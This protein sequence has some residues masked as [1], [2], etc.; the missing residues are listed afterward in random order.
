MNNNL[1]LILWMWKQISGTRRVIMFS[2]FLGVIRVASSMFF[3]WISKEMI[4]SAVENR[5]N[6]MIF[7]LGL[8][9]TM[10]I[11]ILCTSGQGY[12]LVR[13]EAYTSNKLRFKLFDKALN[14]IWTGKEKW[15]SGDVVNRLEEDVRVMTNMLCGVLPGTLVTLMQFIAAFIF[16]WTM[17]SSL[18][19]VIVC[20]LPAF[21]TVAAFAVHKM[22]KFTVDIRNADG[23]V[24]SLIQESLQKR[25]V[26]ITL[27]RVNYVLDKLENLQSILFDKVAKRN[28]F[29]VI[30][31]L[32]IMS[33]FA[34]GYLTA[35]IWGVKNMQEGLVSFGMLSAFLQ[36]VGQ[37]QRPTADL[38]RRL[39]AMI[40]SLASA[41]R[42]Y[43]IY[44][45]EQ[46]SID[47]I[48]TKNEDKLTGIK[49]LNV[50]FGYPDSKRKVLNNFS[51][52]F[53]PGTSTAIIGETGAGKSTIMKLMLGL[54]KPEEGQVLLYSNSQDG[55]PASVLTRKSIVYVPQGNSLLSGSIRD[56]LVAGNKHINEDKIN[57]ALH[58]AAAEFV[59]ELPDGLDT[60][61]GEGGEGL[62]EGQAQR[63]AVA[64]AL[65]G[66]GLIMLFDEFTSALD[67]DTEKVLME[68][69]TSDNIEKTMVF[70][71]HRKEIA[72]KCDFVINIRKI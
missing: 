15:H 34:V 70:I 51:F 24:Q 19:Y 68:R 21:L 16:L 27:R 5:G 44:S 22:K 60:K 63:I 4:D 45:T 1:N 65:L 39:P 28:H 52:D 13:A 71:T 7:A 36:L 38:S 8:I 72:D 20:I 29:S 41:E 61:C 12:L 42:L 35:F 56:N 25:I 10:F 54:L 31:R 14:G 58:M 50:T 55:I 17:N 46:E 33:G 3:I 53:T 48:E 9:I 6:I 47:L 32:I 62:S 59:Y 37:I 57:S 49:M 2:T 30:S 66:G 26:V 43:E 40:H 69:L 67:S 11:E 23:N 64:R 18:A